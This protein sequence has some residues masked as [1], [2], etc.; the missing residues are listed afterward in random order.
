MI[1]KCTKCDIVF[2][3]H[4]RFRCLYCN[5]LLMSISPDEAPQREDL[6]GETDE[7]PID[8]EPGSDD[9]VRARKKSQ[10]DSHIKK[11]FVPGEVDSFILR[12]IKDRREV[13]YDRRYY[14]VGSY[15]NSRT[16]HFMYCFSRNDMKMG[17]G[18]RRALIQPL[19][20]SSL[21]TLPWVVVNLID[22]FF[23]R[24]SYN[25]FCNRC[26]WKFKKSSALKA[27][28]PKEC[29]YNQEYRDIILDILSGD[30]IRSEKKFKEMAEAKIQ[31]GQ[32]SAYQQLCTNH[33]FSS[34]VLDVACVWFSLFLLAGS[35]IMLFFPKIE[36]MI[37][38]VDDIETMELR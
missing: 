10:E 29:E 17:R 5:S 9:F 23:L 7:I 30:I 34:T 36:S 11:G 20:M 26:G 8:Q 1:K 6:F 19:N 18:F 3:L 37:N 2:N 21:L 33:N 22:T 4:E 13:A 32:R 38:Q 35:F 31:V 28:D 27:H 12:V 25:G 15:F 16:L 14:I 24:L